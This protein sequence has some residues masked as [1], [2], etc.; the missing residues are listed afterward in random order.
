MAERVV[1][2]GKAPCPAAE[3]VIFSVAQRPLRAQKDA[4]RCTL[5]SI[6]VFH[7]G[8]TGGSSMM[9][10]FGATAAPSDVEPLRRNPR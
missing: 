5:P 10:D 1:R 7:S 9:D 2:H 3:P 4:R 8:Q 6:G